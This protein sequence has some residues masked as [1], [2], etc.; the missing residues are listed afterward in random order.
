MAWLDCVPHWVEIVFEGAKR[1]VVSSNTSRLEANA[2]FFRLLMK[3]IFGP[4]TKS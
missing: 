2:S 3:V 4:L 1:K